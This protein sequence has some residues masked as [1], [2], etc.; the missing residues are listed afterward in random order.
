M[1]KEAVSHIRIYKPGISNRLRRLAESNR[2]SIQSEGMLAIELHLEANRELLK[3]GA[4]MPKK[5]V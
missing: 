3:S 2:R 1:P 4:R 5:K